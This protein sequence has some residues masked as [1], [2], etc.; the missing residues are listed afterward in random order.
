MKSRY[1]E[2][3][4]Q[5]HLITSQLFILVTVQDGSGEM[6]VLGGKKLELS[7]VI[8]P[9]VISDCALRNLGLRGGVANG[10]LGRSSA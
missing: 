4:E 9:S 5:S 10:G 7:G 1:R 3:V 8:G 6:G 2:K